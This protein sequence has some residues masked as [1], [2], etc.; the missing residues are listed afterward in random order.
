MR[1]VYRVLPTTS[2]LVV[3]AASFALSYVAI[4]DVAAE[5]GA[6]P[7]HLAWLVPVV[8]DGGIIC[9]SVVIWAN[10]QLGQRRELFPFAVVTALVIVSVV[11]NAS[12]A[13]ATP[14]AKVIAALP[15][16]VLLATLELVAASYR[17]VQ[18]AT[19]RGT[20]PAEVPAP[21]PATPVE[22]STSTEAEESDGEPDSADEPSSTAPVKKTAARKTPAKKAPAKK[23]AARTTPAKKAPA[24]APAAKRTTTQRRTPATAAEPTS[25]STDIA[26]A[27]DVVDAVEVDRTLVGA[28]ATNGN[29]HRN[30]AGGPGAVRRE[31]RV[32]SLPPEVN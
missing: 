7:P 28:A 6:V 19:E 9:G 32:E 12:H 11:V 16:L 27:P 15:P 8:I 5:I 3:A 23:T 17:S 2:A 4:R 1:W 10:A 30:G 21:A 18:R 25:V 29:G 24:K 22:P 26:E 14:L 20:A 31:L 13:A